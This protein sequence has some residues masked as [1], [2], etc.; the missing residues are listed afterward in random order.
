METDPGTQPLTTTMPP[1]LV[2][3][4]IFQPLSLM[5]TTPCIIMIIF[6]ITIG[7]LVPIAVITDRVI[8]TNQKKEEI[9][10]NV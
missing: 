5:S 2:K 6:A 7:V 1:N 8:E 9:K 10:E 3:V 4:E